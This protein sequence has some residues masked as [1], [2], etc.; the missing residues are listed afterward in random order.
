ME[1]HRKSLDPAIDNRSLRKKGLIIHYIHCSLRHWVLEEL[2]KD[3][4]VNWPCVLPSKA[5]AQVRKRSEH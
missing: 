2:G 4:R 5:G 3:T 1:T